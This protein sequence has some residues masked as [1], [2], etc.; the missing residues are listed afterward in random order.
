MASLQSSFPVHGWQYQL[1]Q[2]LLEPSWQNISIQDALPQ[3]EVVA[4]LK[5]LLELRKVSL[6]VRALVQSPILHLCNHLSQDG[7]CQLGLLPVF[8]S[9]TGNLCTI[10][11]QVHNM[12]VTPLHIDET[13][14]ALEGHLLHGSYCHCSDSLVDAQGFGH[15]HGP[16]HP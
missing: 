5:E 4:F 11:Y 9:H 12:Q 14:G 8:G 13:C 15:T 3:L 7:V 6:P 10:L 1:K 16:G 2:C